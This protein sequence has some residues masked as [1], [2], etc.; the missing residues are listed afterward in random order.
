MGTD[1]AVP[2]LDHGRS[3]SLDSF[4]EAS[5]AGETAGFMIVARSE[6]SELLFWTCAY[7]EKGTGSAGWVVSDARAVGTILIVVPRDQPQALYDNDFVRR[8]LHYPEYLLGPGDL[9]IDAKANQ[10]TTWE[11]GGR[12]LVWSPPTWRIEGTHAGVTAD[13][14]CRAIAEPIWEMGPFESLGARNSAGYDV[15][16][17]ANGKVSV[18]G[19]VY[20][21]VDGVGQHQR[22]VL[23]EGRNIIRELSSRQGTEVFVGDCF[24]DGVHLWFARGGRHQ[25]ET[26]HVDVT[27]Q[28]SVVMSNSDPKQLVSLK[29]TTWWD[30]PRSGLHM[31]ATWSLLAASEGCAVELEIVH[32]ARG[33]WQYLYKSGF[34][35]LMWILSHASGNVYLPN[36]RTIEVNNAL[37][38]SRWGRSILTA[39]EVLE[40]A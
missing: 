5:N 12:R 36:G 4:P 29:P 32:S 18:G 21:V 14:T 34:V 33:Y 31:P 39:N 28:P 22:E 17:Q 19:K 25:W 27:G 23:G 11:L 6:S 35:L 9:R 3:Y 13:L 38:G 20:P 30:D 2:T 40:D 26:C 8:G 16:I 10:S 37:V 15:P 24:A 7:V 1:V